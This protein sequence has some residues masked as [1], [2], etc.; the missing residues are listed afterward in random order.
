MTAWLARF[1]YLQKIRTIFTTNYF[2]LHGK[3]TLL[4]DCGLH[5]RVLNYSYLN[6]II[7]FLLIGEGEVTE[8]QQISGSL[9][10]ISVILMYSL[11]L[12]FNLSP[13]HT[14]L[15][16]GPWGCRILQNNLELLIIPPDIVK[17][18]LINTVFSSSLFFLNL[19]CLTSS[20]FFGCKTLK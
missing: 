10:T 15:W 16:G 12:P 13:F 6:L 4:F 1:Y 17:I 14:N 5:L 9:Q 2:Y 20:F 18:N 3:I 7:L 11:C 8:G 19:V